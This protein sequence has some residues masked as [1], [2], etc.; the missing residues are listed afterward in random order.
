MYYE[1][2]ILGKFCRHLKGSKFGLLFNSILGIPEKTVTTGSESTVVSKGY[3]VYEEAKSRTEV[4][5]V[6]VRAV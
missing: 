6:C 1:Q 2:E 3:V 5:E 4:E